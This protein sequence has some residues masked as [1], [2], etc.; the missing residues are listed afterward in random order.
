MSAERIEWSGDWVRDVG[1]VNG[2]HIFTIVR[3]TGH[4]VEGYPFRIEHRLPG[5]AQ[6]KRVWSTSEAAK[7]ACERTFLAAMAQLG[8]TP[9]EEEEK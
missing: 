2:L 6:F 8:F 5:Y 9:K 7:A 3:T 1:R 4:A